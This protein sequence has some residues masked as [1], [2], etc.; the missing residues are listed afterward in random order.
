[1]KLKLAMLAATGAAAL[2]IAAFAQE[3]T[4]YYGALGAGYTFENEETTVSTDGAVRAGLTPFEFETDAEIEDAVNIY[5]AIGKYFPYAFR[6]ELELST[7]TQDVALVP[8]QAGVFAG[9]PNSGDDLGDIT[10]T[11]LMANLY[12]DFPIDAAGRLRPFVGVGVG[13]AYVEANIENTIGSLPAVPSEPNSVSVDDEDYVPA[14]QGLAGLTLAFTE[15]LNVDL[16][17]RYLWLSEGEFDGFVND[18]GAALAYEYDA[19]EIT[20]GLRWDFAPVAAAPAAPAPVQ[21]KTCFDGSRI[22]VTQTCPPRP[23][24]T[25]PEVTELEPL[26]VYFDYDKSNLTDAANTLIAARAEEAIDAD[27]A[28][29]TVQGNTD[30]AGSASYNQALSARRAKVVS[31]ALVANGV[32]Q[33]A[34]TVEAL[35]ESNPAKPTGDGVR[36]PLNRRTEVTFGF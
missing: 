2:N 7:R 11:T 28:S 5:G 31:D 34:I 10:V 32:D 23:V 30:T 24:D 12:K 21:Y 22:P 18:G 29:V 9:F 20:A 16:R 4:G 14:V 6:G 17:Y 15:Q 1:M 26:V 27:V 13:A 36:E 33:S 19:H 35:G 8:G 25:A 3:E